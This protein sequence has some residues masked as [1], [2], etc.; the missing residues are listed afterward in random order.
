M[1]RSRTHVFGPAGV[2]RDALRQTEY[3]TRTFSRARASRNGFEDKVV[4]ALVARCNAHAEVRRAIAKSDVILDGRHDQVV[5]RQPPDFPCSRVDLAL[6]LANGRFSYTEVK[7]LRG[8]VSAARQVKGVRADV[9]KLLG[10]SY[11]PSYAN[12]HVVVAGLGYE[13]SVFKALMADACRGQPLDIRGF[14]LLDGGAMYVTLI[15]V[16]RPAN[17]YCGWR[18]PPRR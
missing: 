17:L 13:R 5:N 7:A 8:W 9:Q 12:G 14:D 4:D 16:C 11:A 6:P 15:S 1:N 10:L 18:A 2:L 3:S